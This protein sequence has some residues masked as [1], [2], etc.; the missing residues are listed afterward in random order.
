MSDEGRRR[1][2]QVVRTTGILQNNLAVVV[3]AHL[4]LVNLNNDPVEVRVQV[5]NW[6]D[7]VTQTNPVSTLLDVTQMLPGNTRMAFNA[8]VP[9]SFHYEVR[10]TVGC[11]ND[12][13]REMDEN[14]LLTTYGRTAVGGG[15][16]N[17]LTVLDSQFQTVRIDTCF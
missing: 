10:L 16:V 8:A 2:E 6:G 7:A 1:R 9:A 11:R 5:L 4:D 17:G 15:V 13:D 14:V 3:T 12:G